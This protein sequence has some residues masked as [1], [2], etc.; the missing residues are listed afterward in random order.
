LRY[1]SLVV[2]ASLDRQENAACTFRRAEIIAAALAAEAGEWDH[3]G[4]LPADA[5]HCLAEAGLLSVSV[6]DRVRHGAN[7]SY[8]MTDVLRTLTAVGSGDLSIGRL[9]EGHVNA[10]LLVE[11]FGTP[12]QQHRI[13]RSVC[14]FGELLAVWNTEG[15]NPVTL[16]TSGSLCRLQG[17][18]SFASGAGL[19]G[20]AVVTASLSDGTRQML[21]VPVSEFEPRIDRRSWRPLGMRASMS[22]DVDFSGVA[23][24][25][26]AFLGMPDDYFAEPWFSAGCI[27]FGAVQLGGA[28]KILRVVHTHLRAAGRHRDAYQ[29]ERF[30]RMRV[31]LDGARLWLEK[32][33]IALD[34][35]R[36]DDDT[37]GLLDLANMC[38]HAVQEAC[39]LV[40]SLSVQ[41]VGVSGMLAPHPLERLVRDLT[42]Y[43]RQPAP[44]A[45][46][47]S[48]GERALEA[49]FLAW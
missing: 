33:G 34:D 13:A 49:E 42:T 10:L 23:V 46:L 38:R 45:A 11:K 20:T 28:L 7:S 37:D 2:H 1:F 29:R 15:A 12:A 5:I 22:F 18:K 44:D 4:R 17:A 41:S 27:R 35:A 48:V 40:L 39:D 30:A 9:Y 21:L 19:V 3:A 36:S 43:L 25:L 8:A 31:A 47:V 32:A 6:A 26:D 16:A 14:R 24:D